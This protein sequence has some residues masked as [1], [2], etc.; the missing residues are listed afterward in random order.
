MSVAPSCPVLLV[1]DDESFRKGL[2]AALDESHFT[3]T[4]A[5][6]GEEGLEALAARHDFQ[7]IILDLDLPGVDGQAV[8]DHVRDHRG[9]IE[10]R[11]IIV[12]GAHPELRKKFNLSLAEEVL[13]KPVDFAHVAA[14]A[15]RYCA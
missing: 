15:R 13:L 11:I 4:M 6:S 8:L 7:V 2:V 14:R 9:E 5:T 1:E 10:A 3:V 12:T